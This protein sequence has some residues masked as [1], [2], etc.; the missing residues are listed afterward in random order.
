MDGGL[1]LY[2]TQVGGL[3]VRDIGIVFAVNTGV[4]VLAQWWVLK[5]VN[6]RSRTMLLA[7][8]GVLW[9]ISWVVMGGSILLSAGVVLL[10]LCSG[11]A[12]F[13]IA[14]TLWSP[15]LTTLINHVAPDHLRGRYNAAAAVSYNLGSAI[16]P[17]MAGLLIGAQLGGMWIA[18]LVVG[19]LIG[20]A[21]AWSV[22]SLLTPVEDGRPTD[23]QVMTGSRS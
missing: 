18:A 2:M 21:I 8:V 3:P 20:G 13:A 11:M 7:L 5:A 10:A 17:A 6:G 12:I 19:C 4:I 23:G 14:E 1:A 15:I 22:R 9:A 16:G